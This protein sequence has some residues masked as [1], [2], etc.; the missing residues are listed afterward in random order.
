MWEIAIGNGT[1]KG[2]SEAFVA[3]VLKSHPNVSY[4]IVNERGVSVYSVN[5]LV[6]ISR[7]DR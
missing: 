5:W 2:E 1:A 7:V 3:E 6:V 4:V